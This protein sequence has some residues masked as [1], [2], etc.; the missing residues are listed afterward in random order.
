[1]KFRGAVRVPGVFLEVRLY[2]FAHQ[3]LRETA[4][5]S[6]VELKM[7]RPI[8][9]EVF[10]T[11]PEKANSRVKPATIFRVFRAKKLLLEMY[12]STSHLDQSFEKKIILVSALEPQVLQDIMRFIVLTCIEAGEVPLI[13]RIQRQLGI[14]AKLGYK[15]G[16]AFVFFHRAIRRPKLFCA[17]LCLTS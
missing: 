15:G 7:H 9:M 13:T 17:P 8:W 3:A 6:H 10:Y 14:C 5:A 16:N 12:K 4:D 1:M 2:D 11:E